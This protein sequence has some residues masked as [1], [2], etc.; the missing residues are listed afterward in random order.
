VSVLQGL[1]YTITDVKD[2]HE[3]MV[4]HISDHPLFE[5]VSEDELVIYLHAIYIY[6]NI[7]IY[8]YIAWLME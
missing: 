1:L 4:E 8:I 2:L 7:I 5:R 3:W 6:I